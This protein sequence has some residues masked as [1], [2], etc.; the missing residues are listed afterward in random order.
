MTLAV[1][2]EWINQID[3]NEVI[4]YPLQFAN[5]ERLNNHGNDAVY[6]FDEVG[7]G[8]TISSGIMALD[9]LEHNPGEDVLVITTN[10]LARSSDVKPRGQFLS[11]WF[12]KLP[13][14]EL[15]YGSRVQVVNN[16]HTK[17][18]VPRKYGL[19]IIDEAHLFLGEWTQRY[20]NLTN[21]ITAKKV[22]FLT[23]T[24]IK[25]GVL[26]PNRIS[27]TKEAGRY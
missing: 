24:P 27:L 6:L 26:D 23:A 3:P 4:L 1:N 16:H 13:F 5:T 9:F 22:V 17:F 14:Q 20:L 8:K 12:D 7:S 11:D 19:V 21:N 18:K 25:Q 10:A 2:K 15:G